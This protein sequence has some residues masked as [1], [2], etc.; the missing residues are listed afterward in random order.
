MRYYV[1]QNVRYNKEQKRKRKE[2]L[3]KRLCPTT[4][5]YVPDSLQKDKN[6][7]LKII[8]KPIRFFLRSLNF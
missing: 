5:H 6:W 4:N 1:K 8:K 3:R 7:A 2:D